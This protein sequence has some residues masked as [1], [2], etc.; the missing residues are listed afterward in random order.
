MKRKDEIYNELLTE[1][2]EGNNHQ[3][4]QSDLSKKLKISLSVVNLSL[5]P[6]R[7]MNAIE[8]KNRSLNI[9]DKKK[10]LYYWASTRNLRKDIIYSTRVNKPVKQIES[11]MPSDVL[12]AAYSAFKFRYNEVPAD[13]SEVFVYANDIGELMKRFP[14]KDGIPNLIVLDKKNLDRVSTALMFVDLW[15]IK[16]WYA[17]EFL[18]SLESKLTKFLE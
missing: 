17:K 18:K 12:F 11:E 6:L 8:V 3:F 7:N 5:S 2:L 4:T 14:K 13:Y 10:I 15:N 9:I 16:E 1:S